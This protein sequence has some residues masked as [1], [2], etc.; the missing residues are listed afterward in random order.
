MTSGALSR[1]LTG[2]SGSHSPDSASQRVSAR[3]SG[4]PAGRSHLLGLNVPYTG[5]QRV[6]LPGDPQ[7]LLDT[8]GRDGL[9]HWP[10]IL[11]VGEDG[12]RQDSAD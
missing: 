9:G 4:H 3:V 11:G 12:R 7:A 6:H 2:P 8:G 1:V 10:L 5:A